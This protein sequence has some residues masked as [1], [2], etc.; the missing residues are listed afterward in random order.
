MA[1]RKISKAIDSEN[2]SKT[3]KNPNTKTTSVKRGSKSA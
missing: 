1:A 3:I 2:K